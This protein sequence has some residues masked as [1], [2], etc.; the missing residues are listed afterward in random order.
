[1]SPQ[2]GKAREKKNWQTGWWDFMPLAERSLRPLE[3]SQSSVIFCAHPVQPL[4]T[5]RHFSSSKQFVISPPTPVASS[6]ASYG[7]PTLISVA[8]N[9]DWLFAYFPGHSVDGIGALWTRGPQIDN[10]SVKESWSIAQGA[11]P[12]TANW[13][14][15]PRQASASKFL[16]RYSHLN[17][18]H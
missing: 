16:W 10:W 17:L 6:P 3:W 2:K 7:P 9:D 13:L 8:P 1:M 11:A 14:G 4:I 15:L 5:A 18:Y 12:L